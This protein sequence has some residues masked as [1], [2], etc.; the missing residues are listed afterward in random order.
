MGS[1]YQIQKKIK[2]LRKEIENKTRN[3]YKLQQIANAMGPL[4]HSDDSSEDETKISFVSRYHAIREPLRKTNLET[5]WSVPCQSD[6]QDQRISITNKGH[7][8][9]GCD[10]EQFF[11]NYKPRVHEPL[12]PR[13]APLRVGGVSREKQNGGRRTICSIIN[14]PPLPPLKPGQPLDYCPYSKEE[15]PVEFWYFPPLCNLGRTNINPPLPSPCSNNCITNGFPM[16]P[17][18]QELADI[19]K[20]A[21]GW[22]P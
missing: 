5:T 11:Y 20:D 15:L 12:E 7:S 3:L 4:R 14:L 13:Q 2:E 16:T 9:E 19:C 21:L 18:D 22:W 1:R 17:S 10:A 8:A 6:K